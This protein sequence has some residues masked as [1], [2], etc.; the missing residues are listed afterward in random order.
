MPLL[1][2][3]RLESAGSTNEYASHLLQNGSATEFTVIWTLGQYSGKGLG[4]TIWESEPG[5]NL[6][7]SIIIYPYFLDISR[8]FVLNRAI[9]LGVHDYLCSV[10][11]PDAVKIKWPND[12][13]YGD[14]K[15]AGILIENAI[16]D[17]AFRHSI[18][19]IGINMNQVSFPPD[20]PNPVSLREIT[21]TGYKLEEN[22]ERVCE[23][24]KKRYQALSRDPENSPADEY[25]SKLYRYATL[26][27]YLYRNRTIRA[28]ITGIEESGHLLLRTDSGESICCDLKEIVFLQEK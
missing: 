13:Y 9:A 4:G 8:Q 18:V 25:I 26:S 1:N 5:K 27:S 24:I 12:I 10:V 14:R 3:I 20:L 7:F 16:M 6:T 28:S 22:L 19:G 15:V 2:L 17:R 21:G 11:E 23:A